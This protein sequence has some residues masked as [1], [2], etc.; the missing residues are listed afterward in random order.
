MEAANLEIL[1]M[2]MADL[3]GVIE[4]ETRSF[5]A[6]WS[7]QAFVQELT[8]NHYAQYLVAREG[9]RIAGYA[10]M[11]VIL[12][13]AHVTNVAVHPDWRGCGAGEQL[14]RALIDRA[15]ALGAIRMTLEVR[16]SNQVAQG[17]YL[18]LGFKPSGIR[19]GY[20]TETKEDALIMWLDPLTRLDI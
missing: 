5:P 19:K 14:M 9:D 12:D 16:V 15:V 13:E 17:L 4:V 1:P 2:R 7:R 10:G 11:W 6:P 3:D 18:K 20:Y 8:E